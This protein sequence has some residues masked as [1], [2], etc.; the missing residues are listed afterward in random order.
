MRN[1]IRKIIRKFVTVRNLDF[2]PE[3][4]LKRFKYGGNMT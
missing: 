1:E 3:V 2:T 4:T